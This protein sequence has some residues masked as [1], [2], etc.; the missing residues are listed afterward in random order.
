[1]LLTVA[2]KYGWNLAELQFHLET[3][4]VLTKRRAIL[5]PGGKV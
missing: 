5:D 2:G 4:K 1:M 3:R